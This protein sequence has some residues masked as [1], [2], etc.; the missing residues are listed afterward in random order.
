[1]EPTEGF[2]YLTS[3]Q[4]PEPVLVHGYYCSDCD[5]QFVFGFNVHD[6]GGIVILRDI[7]PMTTVT[8]VTIET[9][10]KV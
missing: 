5:G 9:I 4:E 8:R 2:Y 1:M 3:P 7:S 10:E 6:G